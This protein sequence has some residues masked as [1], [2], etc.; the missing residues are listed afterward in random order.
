M[1][2]NCEHIW[3]EISDYIENDLSPTQR[4]SMDGHLRDCAKCRSVLDGT[5]NVIAL[6]GDERMYPLP[7]GF[8]SRLRQRLTPIPSWWSSVGF[9]WMTAAAATAVM[10]GAFIVAS[11]ASHSHP[12]TRSEMALPAFKVPDE[13]IVVVAQHG[14]L[15]HLAECGYL[16]T[17]G[18]PVRSMTA[19]EAIREG[20]VPCVRCL[21]EYALRLALNFLQRHGLMQ[22]G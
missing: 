4:A 9:G 15:F 2:E 5:R 11:V 22:A 21:G 14:K 1:V 12:A 16:H 13:M 20:Y 3:A 19:K 17:E 18:Y 10:A 7:L 6:Y 8:E